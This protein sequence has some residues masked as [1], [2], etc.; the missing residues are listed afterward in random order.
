MT[1]ALHFRW[2]SWQLALDVD[3]VEGMVVLVP[4]CCPRWLVSRRWHW[5]RD[6]GVEFEM[7]V[8]V[9]RGC[10]WRLR[11]WRCDQDVTVGLKTLILGLRHRSWLMLVIPLS[12]AVAKEKK[13][14]VDAP[15]ELPIEPPCVISAPGPLKSP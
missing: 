5:V 6:V 13:C 15:C 3:A 8:V 7:L 14:D 2:G 11:C 1:M 12:M 9:L 4:P 10:S